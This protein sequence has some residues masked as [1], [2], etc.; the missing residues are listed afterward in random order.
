[1]QSS[2]IRQAF[3]DY[4]K[5]RGHLEV[6]SLPLVPAGDPTL[7]FT[8]AGMVQFKPY[9]MGLAEPPAPRLSSVQKVFRAT[10]LDLAG[11]T[12][13]L[14]F[15]EMMGNFSVGEY[16]KDEAID[17]AW[18]FLTNVCKLAPEKL[19]ITIYLDDEVA[20]DAWVRHGVPE[21]R[22]YRYGED[23][24]YWFSGDVGPCGPDSEIFYDFGPQSDCDKC[25]PAHDGHRRFLEIW[26]LVFMMLYQHEDGTR[27]ELP[28]KNIDTGSGL[29]RMAAAL[30]G[31]PDVYLTDVFKPSIE[32]IESLTER[33]YGDDPAADRAF[34]VVAE[35]ARALT[36]LI[37]DGVSPSNE[38]RGYVLR[39]VL[40][41]A[42]YFGRGLGLTGAFVSEV[43][44]EV[45]ER[46]AATHPELT[47]QRTAILRLIRDEE[48][49]FSE[50][51]RRGIDILED[52]M[53]RASGTTITGE[54]AFRLYDTYG[55][56]VEL[57][58]EIAG[59]SGF[60]VD[61]DG[62][63]REM[64]GQRER[65]RASQKF[66]AEEMDAELAA[67]LASLNTSFV[68]YEALEADTTVGA[69]IVDK[70]EAQDVSEGQVCSVALAITPFYP[71]GG[72]QVGD[73]GEIIAPD[74]VLAV[75]D[76]QQIGEGTILHHGTVTR[77]R[78]AVG[79]SVRAR[80]DEERREG[81][82]R[83]H[84][85][86]HLVHSALREVLGT[87][88][89]QTG[90]LVAPDRLRFDFSHNKPVTPEE[91]R[92]VE[93]LVNTKVRQD[94]PVTTRHTTYQEA[95]NEGVIAFFGDKY[96]AE[97][98][99]VEV[100]N[101]VAFSSAEL[102]GGTHCHRTGQVGLFTIISEGSVGSGIRRI[103][104]LTGAASEEFAA[105]QRATLQELAQVVGGAVSEVVDRV[106]AQSG[107]LDALRKRLARTQSEQ[108]RES[109]GGLLDQATSVD[110]S[111]I[112]AAR[113]E[114]GNAEA[115]REMAD[116]LRD[117]IGSG[118]VVLGTVFD[119]KPAFLAM[120][121]SDLT[122]KGV[123]AGNL[124]KQVAALTGG[125]GGG[126][127]EL[128]QAGGRD[129]SRLD[130]ALQLA[131]DVARQSLEGR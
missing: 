73:C 7:L 24:N 5:E 31:S 110:G 109:L 18:D 86:T 77:G 119:G 128:A 120:V 40:R 105:R 45:I 32:M 14:T 60:S 93:A 125:G 104:A 11:D 75:S 55:L 56:P 80:V 17:W 36:F 61:L 26:N 112:L 35:H 2:E 103:E 46:M 94:V 34:R 100:P 47:H 107:E 116:S 124:V 39:R 22:I 69:L 51:L 91:L 49:R 6:P 37:A 117:Q 65:A 13:H 1:M 95:I 92:R 62:F 126:R 54:D 33:H 30:N 25:E 67:R 98:R 130:E 131:R 66:T 121:T 88:V 127:P 27:T 123:H 8:S 85:A 102:C 19:R 57:T 63:E 114:A 23:Q 21:E 20:H 59:E 71:E 3:L 50:T 70:A 4:F 81:T 90:S 84:T 122:G 58:R 68:G 41:R 44:Q 12:S 87:H 82:M 89:R 115:L 129:P 48:E 74:G 118:I 111:R 83:N 96:S 52:T 108:A 79:D 53:E 78:V 15:F 72:G 106:R 29:E 28:T 38:G 43:A 42:V 9:F 76:T 10:D 64:E 16:F 97:V 99:V 113:V 101:G